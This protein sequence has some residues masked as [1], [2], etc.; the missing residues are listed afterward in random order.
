M[1]RRNIEG[2]AARLYDLLGEV[3]EAAE[4]ARAELGALEEDPHPDFPDRM[5]FPV[6]DRARTA[7]AVA[8]SWER[9]LKKLQSAEVPRG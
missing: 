8:E 6:L 3:I 7:S 2:D 5:T 1:G 9:A 4:R